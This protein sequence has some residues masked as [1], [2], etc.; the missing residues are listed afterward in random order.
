MSG[1]HDALNDIYDVIKTHLS[2]KQGADSATETA[3]ELKFEIGLRFGGE[4][5]YIRKLTN[6]RNADIYEKFNGNNH[7]ELAK[8][9]DL[10][11]RQIYMIV[12]SEKKRF[13]AETQYNLI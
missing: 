13:I 6:E 4:Q 9:Y 12:E 7:K 3:E 5:I 2:I 11:E 8:K 1:Q 10:T